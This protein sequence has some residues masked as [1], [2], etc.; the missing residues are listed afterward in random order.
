MLMNLNMDLLG[1]IQ[2]GDI[3]TLVNLVTWL[4]KNFRKN[5]EQRLIIQNRIRQVGDKQVLKYFLD[6]SVFIPHKIRRN[7]DAFMGK[8]NQ[9]NFLGIVNLISQEYYRKHIRKCS[10]RTYQKSLTSTG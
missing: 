10:D 4:L 3:K 5:W 2:R 9:N 8:K 6:S 1:L 7:L